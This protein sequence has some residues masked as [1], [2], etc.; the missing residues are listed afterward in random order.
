MFK[1]STGLRQS[2]LTAYKTAFNDGVI[3][4]YAGQAP[5]NPKDAETGTLLAWIT[6]NGNAFTPGQPDN[7]LS[8]DAI[9]NE[10]AQSVLAKSAAEVWQG[11]GLATGQAGYFRF[12]DN[13][14]VTGE[15]SVAVRFQGTVG[16]ANAD[17]I[18]GSVNIKAGVPVTVDECT[19]TQ[20]MNI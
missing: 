5:A 15:S 3:G 18:L 7:G 19:I 14:R 6:Q 2:L 17:M 9:T 1:L 16:T 4:I 12:Y 8:F 20:P 10:A 13:S 11:T